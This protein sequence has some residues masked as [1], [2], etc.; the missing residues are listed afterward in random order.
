MT[1]DITLNRY[2][3]HDPQG[4]MYALASQVD[5]VRA[6][7]AANAAAR[8]ASAAPAVSI[9]LQ[10]DAIQPLTLRVLPGECLVVT[11]ENRLE[12]EPA[13]FHLHGS[14]LRVAATG[15]P[16]IAANPDAMARPG[17]SVTYEWMVQS[18][19]SEATHYFHSHGDARTQTSHG[20]FGALVVEPD[21]S[22]W[23]DP[24]TGAGIE[25]GWQAVIDPPDGP[26]FRE[27]AIYYHEV[28]NEDYRL[29]DG[30]DLLVPVVDPITSAYRP[31]A[32]ALNY[33]SEP[34]M[35]RL[36]L[37]EQVTGVAD[38]SLEYS[39]YTFGDPATPILRAYVGE[40]VKQRVV[41]GGSEVFHVHH[42]HGGTTR[43]PRQPGVAGTDFAEGLQKR[44][45]SVPEVTERTDAQSLGPSETFDVEP[46]CAA[47]GCQQGVGDFMF[48]CHVAHHYF[49]GMWSIWRTYNTLQDG[50][51]S[52]DSLPPFAALPDDEDPPAAAVTSDTLVGTTV[53]TGGATVEVTSEGLSDL[54]ESQLPPGG[55]PAD[56][57]ASV[58]DWIRDGDRYLNEPET[59]A[60]WPGYEPEQPGL[61]PPIRFD[62]RTGRLAYPMLRPHLGRRPPFAP[63]HGPAPFLD[64]GGGRDPPQ[65]GASGPRSL[66]PDGTKPREFAINAIRTPVM[67]NE[68]DHIL[69]PNGMLFVLRSQRDQVADDRSLQVPLALR[70]NAG[71][72]CVDVLLRSELRDDPTTP[73]SKVGIHIHFVQFDVQASDG[74]DVGFNYEQTIRPYEI[75]GTRITAS[76]AA[77]SDTVQVENASRFQAG[78]LVGVGMDLDEGFEVAEIATV[79]GDLL[80]FTHPLRADHE[81]EEIVSSE[82]VR[83]RWYPDAQFGTAYFHDHVDA[84][85]TWRHGLF[86]AL[87]AE[88]PGATWTDPETGG[89]LASGPIADVHTDQ[90]VGHDVSGSFRELLLFTQ[91]DNPLTHVRRSLGGTF[92][93]RAEPLDGRQG[94]PE[95]RFSSDEHGDP[96]TPILRAHLGD[97]IVI[98]DLVGAANEVHTLHVDGHWFRAERFSATSPPISTI[99]VGISERYDVV[100]PEAGGPQLMPGDYLYENGRAVKLEEGNWGLIRVL[101]PGAEDLQ[102]LPRTAEQVRTPDD[103]C[104]VDAPIRHF[105]VAA[106]EAPLP[107]LDGQTGRVFATTDTA[108]DIAEGTVQAEPLVLRATVGDC[109]E[110]DLTNR[111]PEQRVSFR[112]DLLARDPS[113]SAGI[114]AGH[115]PDQAV[116]PGASRIYRL[117]AHPTVG[118]TVALVRDGADVLGHPPRGLYGAI[119]VAPPGSRFLDP[120]TG[121]ELGGRSSWRAD[122]HGPDG[123]AY[124]DFVLFFHD[125]DESIGSHRM[126]YTTEVAGTVAVNYRNESLDG[127][128]LSEAIADSPSTPLLEAVVGDPVRLH[129]VAPWS[130]QAQVFALE[131]HRWPQ[132]PGLDGTPLLSSRRLAGLQAL[133]LRLDGGAGGADQLPGDYLYGNHRLPYAEAGAWGIFRVHAQPTGNL[134]AL[135]APNRPLTWTLTAVAALAA[136]TGLTWTLARSR[137]RRHSLPPDR[138]ADPSYNRG[139]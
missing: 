11:L 15:E 31:G 69:D 13:S 124:R 27:F 114:A 32:R 39:S 41:H 113:T 49:A 59:G 82:F 125:E 73:F 88:P 62:P 66:C 29:L 65:P 137:R 120:T 138:P 30:D 42:V 60:S 58:L 61:R 10:G 126:P 23:T 40:P 8:E 121:E 26:A 115:E 101:E 12:D 24:L 6:E 20:L 79:D 116:T 102:P 33:R 112:T 53:E 44:P 17:A 46:E 83:Y 98:R 117:Y 119:V 70:T 68:D 37:G 57:D 80:R 131:G 72:D 97:P 55:T 128:R 103:V 122:V 38:E 111:L 89:P 106:F 108:D 81:A 99:D 28:G 67:I 36:R 45:P 71:E 95:L 91:D 133:T 118:Q 22:R 84:L 129:V 85:T 74:V 43:W 123:D 127:R 1:V 94:P 96:E 50:P 51:A 2:L 130:E 134:Q 14:A 4:R 63:G 132:E 19:E 109:I 90:P 136:L 56:G 93:L 54:V 107:M 76:V 7:E 9:G 87:V 77:G 75:E 52:T 92:N 110:V 104:P 16:A 3:D 47:G 48:H 100:I 34:F 135:P 25:T 139:T 78:S 18:D 105:D 5:A 35:N 86:G 21:G 64:P